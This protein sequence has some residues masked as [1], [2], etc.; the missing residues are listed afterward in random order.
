MLL[1]QEPPQEAT[2]P[3][4]SIKYNSFLSQ[5]DFCLQL[6]IWLNPASNHLETLNNSQIIPPFKGNMLSL[7][8]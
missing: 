2:H 3:F 6:E 4:A 5:S 8:V 7:S 1:N